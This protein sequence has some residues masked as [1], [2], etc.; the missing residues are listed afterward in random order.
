MKTKIYVLI[1]ALLSAWA[2]AP[3]ADST[4]A[5][6]PL[7]TKS[8]DQL[9]RVLQSDANRKAKADAC[10]ELAVVGNSQAVPVLVGLLAN[11][12][13]SHMARYALET[14]PGD[15]VNPA[16]RS[17]LTKLQ[18][19]Q[20]VGVIGSLGV[21][22]DPAAVKPL[23]AL[24][25]NTDPQIAQAAARALGSIGT[26]GAASAI[27]AALGKTAPPN[28]LAFCEGLFRCAETLAANGKTRDAIALYDRLRGLAEVPNSV[29]AGA[30]RGSIVV[31]GKNGDWLLRE[32]L[33]TSDSILF[34]AAIRAA[35]EMP[36]PQVTEMLAAKLPQLWPEHKIVVIQ[37]LGSRGDFKAL[38]PLYVEAN[39]GPKSIRLA[40]IRAIAATGHSL[41][42][43]VLVELLDDL[44]VQ[45]ES[46][47][48][49]E[50]E[51]MHAV[52]DGLAGIPGREADTAALDFLKSPQ[53][54]RRLVGID[55]VGRRRM[56]VALPGLLLAATDANPKVRA[57]ALQRVGKL[58]T[59]AEVAALIDILL[60]TS[61]AQDFDGLATALTDICI[62]TGTPASVTAPIIKAF[63]SATPVQKAALLSVLGALGGDKALVA[64]RGALTDP[65]PEVHAAALRA[66]TAWPEI[67]AA[68]DLL[69]IAR[70]TTS[71][72]ERDLAFVGFVRLVR[73]SGATADE[74]LRQ[75]SQ[76]AT[77]ASSPS[78]KML[79]LAGLGDIPSGASLRVVTPYLSDPAVVEEAGA[80]AVRISEKLDP[81]FSDEIGVA[82]NQVLKSAKSPPVLEAA[83]KRMAQL[84][85]PV[86]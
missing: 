43:K 5:P 15:S 16:L 12:E 30:L 33:G 73:E 21:R 72:A 51:I 6:T 64:V 3:A 41:S 45:V 22:R 84:K 13:L 52:Q 81:K 68:P 66:L 82:L 39:H 32:S 4:P 76:A 11:E 54:N 70:T 36:R 38:P 23:A 7:V 47:E 28:R 53:A 59:A 46:I 75:L 62:R 50:H 18:G 65:N 1:A 67:A 37:A 31:R 48:D 19:R 85:L 79:V 78:E 8:A 77:L 61:D 9:I 24:L 20:L 56:T 17:E 10:R 60:R 83:R 14:I 25:K 27:S 29:R 58:G 57:S 80:V 69:Q 35:L 42:V 74:K 2:G 71:S 34:D 55:L 63:A 40:A 44:T 49:P 26:T 86:Q